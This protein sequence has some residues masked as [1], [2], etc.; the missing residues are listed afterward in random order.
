MCYV[1][2]V[3]KIVDTGEGISEENINKLFLDFGK[4]DE[5][6]N[7]NARG[8]GLGLSICKQIIQKMGGRVSVKSTIGK[9]TTFKIECSALCK[10]ED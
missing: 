9:G 2:Y 7:M 6:N 8:T 4:L 3:I 10:I 1:D 5:H